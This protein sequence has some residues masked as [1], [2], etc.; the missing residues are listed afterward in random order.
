MVQKIGR[1]KLTEPE[2]PVL[3]VF[4]KRYT[5]AVDFRTYQIANSSPEYEDMVTSYIAK[6]EKKVK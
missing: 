1:A 6:L 4:M 3:Q 5:W 2:H